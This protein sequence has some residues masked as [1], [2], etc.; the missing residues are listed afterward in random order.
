MQIYERLGGGQFGDVYR[1]L[2]QNS[3]V[4]ALKKLKYKEQ[5]ELFEKEANILT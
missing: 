1:G 2:W 3:I 5:S 4:V